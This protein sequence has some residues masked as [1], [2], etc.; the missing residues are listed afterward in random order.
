M[1][2]GKGGKEGEGR[3]GKGQMLRQMG[4]ALGSAVLTNFSHQ[5]SCRSLNETSLSNWD[6]SRMMLIIQ[7]RRG[8]CGETEGGRLGRRKLEGS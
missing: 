1:E 7:L 3:R 2:K 5:S 6:V 4:L 8:P